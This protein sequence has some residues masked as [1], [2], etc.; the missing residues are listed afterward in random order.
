M[1]KFLLILLVL[2]KCFV[3]SAQDYKTIKSLVS[4]S[5]AQDAKIAL[6]QLLLDEQFANQSETYLLKATVYAAVAVDVRNKTRGAELAT[7]ADAAFTKYRGTDSELKMMLGDKV[8]QN[9]PVN[10]YSSYYSQGYDYYVA[11]NWESAYAKMKKAVEY[12]DLLIKNKLVAVSLDTNVVILAGVTAENAGQ[13]NEAVKYY[14]RLANSKITGDGFESVYRFLLSYSFQNKDFVS[15]EKYKK[16]GTELYPQSDFF[17]FDKVDFA[18]GL[19]EKFADKLKALEDLSVLSPND[20]KTNEV[21]GELIYDQLNPKDEETPAPPDFNDLERKMLIAFKKSAA[22]KPGY[23]NP[24]IYIGDHYINKAVKIDKERQTVEK[25]NTVKIKELDKKYGEALQSA[26]EPYR[27]AAEIFGAKTSIS[28]ND[29]KQYKK[30]VSYLG[31][32]ANYRKLINKDKPGELTKY[33]EELKKW[34]DLY[35]SI[36]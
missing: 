19:Q 35:E 23:E 18:V 36:K 7:E 13:K 28:I 27:K 20:W 22:A 26:D 8:Y 4:R 12:S 31:D 25:T 30:V 33:T 24:Y 21:L 10:I 17:K 16:L 9:A 29:K 14:S 11:K 32:I 5:R 6:D 15:F 34:N 3:S 1:K 2:G